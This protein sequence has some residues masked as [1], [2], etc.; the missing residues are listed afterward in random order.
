MKKIHDVLLPQVAPSVLACD[1][2][3][4]L[5]QASETKEL[6]VKI[7]HFD[8]MDGKFVSKKTSFH[9]GFV[10]SHY[11]DGFIKD[12][13]LMVKNPLK[14]VPAFLEAGA[15]I[16]TFHLEAYKYPSKIKETIE[17]IKQGGALAGLSIKPDTPVEA[18]IPYLG[19]VD[20]VLLMSVEPGMGG[21]EFMPEAV[22]RAKAIKSLINK[23][24]HDVILE[25]DG[26]INATTAKL[27]RSYIDIFV[28]GTYLFGHSDFESRMQAILKL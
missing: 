28:S 3:K 8:V 4:A 15:N 13:H 18:L 10:M 11:L 9:P 21:Q 27:V 12:V 26:G 25:I 1:R 2:K 5:I 14:R 7:L 22:N 20:L 17:L 23:G 6:G 24:K 16:I 19:M